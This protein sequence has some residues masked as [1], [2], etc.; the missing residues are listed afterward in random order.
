MGIQ[1]GSPES[2]V[3]S[4][5]Q[6]KRSWNP[7]AGLSDREREQ[8]RY[9]LRGLLAILAMVVVASLLAAVVITLLG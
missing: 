5:N 6:P 9:L 8:V 4:E 2:V 3:M 1:Y 7:L